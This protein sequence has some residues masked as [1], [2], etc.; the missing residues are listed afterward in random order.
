V[1]KDLATVEEAAR[2]SPATKLSDWL[3]F[4]VKNRLLILL[5]ILALLL[6]AGFLTGAWLLC[7]IGA[8]AAI[9][10][11]I[12]AGR[13]ARA[14]RL[15]TTISDPQKILDDLR[16]TPPGADFHF[17][18]SDPI[19]PTAVAGGTQVTTSSTASSSS[20]DAL[21]F[22][23]VT[24]DT[25]TGAGQPS[26]EAKN[27]RTAALNLNER[28]ALKAPERQFFRF[29]IENATTKLLK[30]LDPF[31][32]FPRLVASEIHFPFDPTWLLTFEHL[33]PAMA[34]P[35]FPDAMY[36]KLRDI[37][38]ELL[39]P[40][41][42]LVPPNTISLLETNPPFIEAYMAGLNHEFGKELLWREYPTDQRG[43]YFR[44]FWDVKGSIAIDPALTPEELAERYKDIT[45]MDGWGTSSTL[46]SHRNPQRPAGKQLVLIVRGE[47][48]KKYPNTVIY[49]QKAHIYR[50]RNGSPDSS[51]EP[52]IHEIKT[53]EERE[54]EIKFPLFHA[55]IEPDVR[56]FGF[57]L[58]A[59]A[60]KGM[61]NPK[62]EKD[63]WG[64]Y[65]LIQQSPG[66]PRF[67]MDI[68]FDPDDDATTPI[69]WDDLGWDKYPDT[70]GFIRT[71]TPPAPAFFNQLSPTLKSQWGTHSADMAAILYQ[72]PVM[73]AIHAREMLKGLHDKP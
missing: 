5:L 34:Y 18:V 48:L 67:G 32:T 62:N 58:T 41:L 31:A 42:E 29:D 49:A 22:T 66:E 7:G 27:F 71:A 43:S 53:E 14:L 30:A 11:Y 69:T 40:N 55:E 51:H 59:A 72:Q 60:A 63:N 38:S 39:L 17:T 37:S 50:D 6:I 12:Y 10:G 44:Q 70:G 3:Q 64:W 57:D 73:I 65:F 54:S 9:G 15:A 16:A 52:I 4:V 2:Q 1:P 24:I 8:L 28:L 47:L 25:R 33:I 46:G 20:A 56:F 35:D 21:R 13:W 36:E 45:P 68:E 19:M 23:T 26:L 61:E